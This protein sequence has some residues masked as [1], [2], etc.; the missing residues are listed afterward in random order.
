MYWSEARRKE[1]VQALGF[2]WVTRALFL[3]EVRSVR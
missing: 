2:G 1:F 3:Y